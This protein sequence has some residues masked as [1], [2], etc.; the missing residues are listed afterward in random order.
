MADVPEVV[1]LIEQHQERII[2]LADS[3]WDHPELRWEEHFAVSEQIALAEAEGFEVTPELAG[4]PTAFAAEFG[5]GGPVI[6][7]LGEYDALAD[8]S[9]VENLNIPTPAPNNESGNGHGCAHH[10][11]GGGSLLAAIAVKEYLVR[12]ELAGRVRYYGCPA[13]EGGGGKTYLV[14][15]GAFDDVDAAFTW[16]PGFG[17]GVSNS[18]MLVSIQAYFRFT[19]QSAHAAFSPAAGRSALDAVE[20]MNVGVNY[21]REHMPDDARVHYAVLDTGGRSPN[22]VQ[23]RAESLYFVRHPK[24]AEA[25]ELFERV[26]RIAEGAALMTGTTWEVELDTVFAELVGNDTLNERLQYLLETVGSVPFDDADYA[27]AEYFRSA[28]A[29]GAPTGSGAQAPALQAAI[30]PLSTTRGLTHGSTDV[31]DVSQVAPTAQLGAPCWVPGTPPHSWQAV[32]QG[33]T[34]YARKATVHTATVMA[35]AAIDLLEDGALLKQAQKEHADRKAE[36]PYMRPF[37]PD[38]LPPALRKTD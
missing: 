7:I 1:S 25:Y 38:V 21:M 22:V 11:L 24:T 20:L 28:I 30:R 32:A 36:E 29:P 3:I 35:L 26:K 23:P 8:L 10:L 34:T 5:R 37:G 15:R 13:E 31:A 6:A 12:H 14:C 27:E 2:A 18:N 17:S 16:H 4:I 9:Q 19:G 33:K